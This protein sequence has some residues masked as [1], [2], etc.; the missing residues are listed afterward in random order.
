MF[1]NHFPVESFIKFVPVHFLSC[2]WLLLNTWCCHRHSYLKN[3]LGKLE[4]E[5][6]AEFYFLKFS[7]LL[8]LVVRYVLHHSFVTPW[9]VGGQALLSMGFPRQEYLNEFHVFLQGVFPIQWKNPCLL[10]WQTDCLPLNHQGNLGIERVESGR[11]A[12]RL[13]LSPPSASQ[14]R[15]KPEQELSTV[16]LKPRL[17]GSNLGSTT[18]F[19]IDG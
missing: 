1:N 11:Q 14:S 12:G 9:T 13:G 4:K 5:V 15:S 6:W 17:S 2:C 3:R 18:M 7:L 10:H 19:K 16:V 8:L